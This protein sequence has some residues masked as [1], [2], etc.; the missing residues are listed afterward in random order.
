MIESACIVDIYVIGY[1]FPWTSKPPFPT[2]GKAP[3]VGVQAL[4]PW[5][6]P[7]ATDRGRRRPYI[8]ACSTTDD[9]KNTS[10][11]RLDHIGTFVSRQILPHS[12]RH[13]RKGLKVVIPLY[14]SFTP[15]FIPNCRR[16]PG[17]RQI[18]KTRVC[19]IQLRLNHAGIDN[20]SNEDSSTLR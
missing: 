18:S 16:Q 9:I 8:E 20:P 10:S 14:L 15:R 2:I 19:F 5:S 4:L 3:A 6:S 11:L 1:R 17:R 12:E 7:Q 13:R